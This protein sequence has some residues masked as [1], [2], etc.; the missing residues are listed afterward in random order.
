[1]EPPWKPDL[2]E[3]KKSW[4]TK[5]KDDDLDVPDVRTNTV[6]LVIIWGGGI[7]YPPQD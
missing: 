2:E 3:V 1:M 4:E 5:P 7:I 6:E